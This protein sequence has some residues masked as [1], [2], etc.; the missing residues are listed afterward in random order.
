MEGLL[1]LGYLGLFIG[2]FLAST[3][4]PLSSDVLLAG[5]LLAKGNP[6]ICLFV[7]T[8]G[9][10]LG[11]ITS[12]C[13][14]YLGKWKWIEKIFKVT[15]EKLEKQKTKIDKYGSL[16]SFFAWF[17]IVG[18]IFSLALGFYKIKPKTCAVFMFLGRFLRFLVWII[19]FHFYGDAF[20]NLFKN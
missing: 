2:T 4:L 7:A 3:L 20:L 19:L 18:D 16:L 6:L 10:W 15:Q 17:P 11:G 9:N 1:G 14:G 12:Y 13:L 8:F 5:M